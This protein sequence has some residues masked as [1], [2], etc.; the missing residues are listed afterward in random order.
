M[1]IVRSTTLTM[2]AVVCG[3]PWVTYGKGIDISQSVISAQF[4]QLGVPVSGQFKK[5]SG[6]V[7]F[8]Q[9]KIEKTTGS[10]DIDVASFDLGDKDYNAEVAKKDWF[11]AKTYPK[12]SFS[13][14]KVTANGALFQAN[15]QLSIK[16]KTLPLQFPVI[17]STINGRQVFTGQVPVKRLFFNIGEGEWKDT[18]I[19][20][21]EVVIKFKIV[22]AP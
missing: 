10:V 22:E 7:E 6:Q 20:A 11:D 19:V 17:I 18:S 12:A 21:D 5:L 1:R 9:K 2:L 15:G 4:K 14:S 3:M 8:D 16:G 13:L